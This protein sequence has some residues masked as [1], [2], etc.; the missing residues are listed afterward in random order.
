MS[1]SSRVIARAAALLA[2]A[3]LLGACAAAPDDATSESEDELAATEPIFGADRIGA[4]LRGKTA[5]IP[6]DLA[7]VEAAF[8][9]GRSCARADS[10]E[11]FV[12]EETQARL[13]NG[14]VTP[15]GPLVPRAVIGGCN[16]GDLSDPAS[17]AQSYSMFVALISD[18][19]QAEATGGDGMVR[20]PV[21]A[22]ALDDKTGTFNFYVFEKNAAGKPEVTRVYRRADGTV[23][24]RR[25]AAGGRATKPAPPEGGGKRCFNCHVNGGPLMNEMRDPWTNW[26]SF[27]KDLPVSRLS[28][29]TKALVSEASPNATTSRS[30]LANDLE[31]I[32]RAA[33]RVHVSGTRSGGRNGWA[34]GESK[35]PGGIGRL[36]RSV[37]C[38]TELNY[39]TATD[40]VPL[41]AF[42]DPDLSNGELVPPDAFGETATPRQMPI[43]SEFD[44]A[45]EG[46]LIDR[47]YITHEMAVAA[48]LFDDEADIFSD[49]RCGLHEAARAAVG[50]VTEPAQVKARLRALLAS[51]AEAAPF[52]AKH[53][54]RHAYLVE[55]LKERP[56]DEAVEARATDYAAE[57]AT[58]FEAMKSDRARVASRDEAR[59]DRARAMFP[60]AATPLP[61]LP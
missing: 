22:M 49:A 1:A 24:E 43:R 14:Q 19:A 10:K 51:K 48:R 30:S 58:R 4:R 3:A 34:R 40:A 25:I 32:M 57:L 52:A 23:L 26:I 33:I 13:P 35:Q 56:S 59:K 11:I 42:I 20:T 2:G 55:L 17:V 36:L 27:K 8:G 38:E 45:V 21:E 47:G 39:A 60:G 44:R 53:P 15:P 5:E 28:G 29:D 7:G 9:I 6:T 12:V 18:P 41:E 16:T 46:F 50:D 31:P 61:L 54:K 37:L